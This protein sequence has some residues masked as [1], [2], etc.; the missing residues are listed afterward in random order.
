MM[1]CGEN[2]E[3]P[4]ELLC[5]CYPATVRWCRLLP[6]TCRHCVTAAPLPSHFAQCHAVCGD[7]QLS[8]NQKRKTVGSGEKLE[9]RLP[10]SRM[11]TGTCTLALQHP[12]L[13]YA[14]AIF[15]STR[16]YIRYSYASTLFVKFG[17]V[18][19]RTV[20][21]EIFALYVAG[22]LHARLVK[23]IMA[24][25]FDWRQVVKLGIG[26]G[27]LLWIRRTRM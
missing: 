18:D 6:S 24:S 27:S 19:D 13:L 22:A 15:D 9:R 12:R 11:F 10:A 25:G 5:Y 2:K 23:R 8:A 26:L 16:T 20:R 7:G 14:S 21:P 17:S 4:A 3:K 1:V